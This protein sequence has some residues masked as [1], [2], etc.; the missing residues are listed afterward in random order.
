MLLLDKLLPSR[1]TRP[2]QISGGPAKGCTMLFNPLANQEPM[3]DGT[4]ED[5]I[6][7]KLPD[8]A[9]KVVWDIGAWIGYHSLCFAN[10]GATV[11]AFEPG[12][13]AYVKLVSNSR[14]NPKLSI[15]RHRIALSSYFGDGI[16]LSSPNI[17]GESSGNHLQGVKESPPGIDYIPVSVI[18][19]RGDHLDISSPDLIKIDVEGSEL[20]VLLGMGKLLDF[21]PIIILEAHSYKLV[22]LCCSLL[23]EKEYQLSIIKEAESGRMFIKA[24]A[25]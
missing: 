18:V 13:G 22:R 5:F 24:E 12:I 10:M 23:R 7:S 14:L 15:Y 4:F 11:H 19:M 17:D 20:N 1:K 3:K 8:L 9:N 25:L 2:I 6:Y 16:L 21:H